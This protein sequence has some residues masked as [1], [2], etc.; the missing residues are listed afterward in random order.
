MGSESRSL[1]QSDPRLLLRLFN[2]STNS[3]AFKFL[4]ESENQNEA[5]GQ[6]HALAILVLF[7]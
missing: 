6:V 2:L 7:L 4:H 5:S 1:W 3:N